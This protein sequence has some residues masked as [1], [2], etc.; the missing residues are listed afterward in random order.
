MGQNKVA[1][2][3]NGQ[4]QHNGVA[5]P[6]PVLDNLVAENLN[7]NENEEGKIKHLQWLATRIPYPFQN[8]VVEHMTACK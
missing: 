7:L 8:S 4:Q 2:E 5:P 3:D 6:F 1:A